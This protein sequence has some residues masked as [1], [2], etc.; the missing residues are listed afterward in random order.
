MSSK[1]RL[2]LA[3]TYYLPGENG[4]KIEYGTNSNAVIIIGANG[5][6]KSKL[7]AWIEQQGF[8]SVHRIGAQ[9]NLNF[10]EHV[11]LKSYSQAEDIVFFGT[12]QKTNQRGKGYRWGFGKEYTTKLIDDFDNVLAAL[13]AKTNL[14]RDKFF[15]E[16]R[17]A[18]SADKEKPH[19]PLTDLDK[20]Q[21]IWSEIFPQRQLEYSDTKF[22]AILQ[23]GDDI[24]KYPSPKMS[25]GERAVLYLASQV[26]CVPENKTLIIDEPEVHLHRSIMNRLWFTLERYRPDCLFIYITHD[27]Q[28]ASSHSD[29][30]KFWVK[31]YDGQNWLIEKIDATDLPEELLL[32]ILGSRKN[33]LFVEGEK[34]SYDTQLYSILYPNYYVIACGGCSQVIARTKAFK[35]SP[36]LHHCSVYGIID[37]DYRSDYEIRKYKESNIFTI[38]VAEVEN[39]FLVEE[40]IRLM[41]AHMGKDSDA[42]FAEVKRFVI[43]QRFSGQIQKQICQSVVAHLKYQLSSAELSKKSE[44]DAKNSLDH[45]IASLDY[46]KT[47]EEQEL[48][49]RGALD[50]NEYKLVLRVFNEKAI[51]TSVGHYF[52][53]ENKQYCNTVLA[54]LSGG[55]QEEI[56]TALLPYL[57][58]EI[59]R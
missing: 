11:P 39:L 4:E 8:E 42:V 51:V 18:E 31:E 44:E 23:K 32:D 59:P 27:T 15:E 55:K 22:S 40:L 43:Q 36:V 45:I 41:A 1:E 13:I 33:V 48:K 16:C 12:D 28:F 35:D 30:D 17:I 26:L 19:T 2:S 50:S 20:L 29:A 52:G 46:D 6:G 37:R 57:P 3:F 25:D 9:R 24:I 34:N 47:K 38:D 10:Q 7:G 53:I 21:E 54:L 58:N 49:F 14:S 5:A 56:V